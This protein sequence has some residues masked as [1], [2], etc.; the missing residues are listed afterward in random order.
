MQRLVARRANV[1]FFL[2][3]ALRLMATSF[4]METTASRSTHSPDAPR[5]M[6]R[7]GPEAV[8]LSLNKGIT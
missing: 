1:S 8:D 2:S 6:G 4:R 5:V 3:A 7:R